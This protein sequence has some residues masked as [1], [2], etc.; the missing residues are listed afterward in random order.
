MQGVQGPK[1]NLKVAAILE[2]ANA[3]RQ[4][5]LSLSLSLSLLCVIVYMNI[6]IMMSTFETGIDWKRRR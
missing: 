5:C 2:K 4:V 1:T 6:I 3:I